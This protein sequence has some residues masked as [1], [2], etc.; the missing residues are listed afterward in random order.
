MF[1]Q[2]EPIAGDIKR[3]RVFESRQQGEAVEQALNLYGQFTALP[4][5]RNVLTKVYDSSALVFE[6]SV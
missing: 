5:L 1:G 4:G 2:A 3:G 6:E